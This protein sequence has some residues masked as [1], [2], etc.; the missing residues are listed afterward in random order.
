MKV[1]SPIAFKFSKL[2]ESRAALGLVVLVV[3]AIFVWQAV[4]LISTGRGKD[5][6]TGRLALHAS[7]SAYETGMGLEQ[8]AA[9]H[10]FG[11]VA[12]SAP[13]SV[14]PTSMPKTDLKLVLVGA[15]TNSETGK[16]SALIMVDRQTKRF[17]VG[18][19]ISA[20]VI[21]YEVRADS[22]VLKRGGNLETLSFP[23]AETTANSAPPN[24][25]RSPAQPIT[26]IA[27]ANRPLFQLHGRPERD[28]NQRQHPQ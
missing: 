2:G 28:G 24:V 9:L 4:S 25:S 12:A 5:I 3:A 13:S 18:D 7:S 15:M 17:L 20:G 1:Y 26:R 10:V 21:L 16:A 11:S 22:V 8:V 6:D 23:R 14:V 19:S 27:P